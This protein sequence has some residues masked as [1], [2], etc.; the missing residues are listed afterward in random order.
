MIN[1]FI[2]NNKHW[3]GLFMLIS[4]IGIPLLGIFIITNFSEKQVF[5]LKFIAL[6]SSISNLIIT[7]IFYFWFNFSSNNF[8]FVEEQYNIQT[9]DIYLGIDGISLYFI[10]LTTIIMVSTVQV[11]SDCKYYPVNFIPRSFI[12]LFS[13]ECWGNM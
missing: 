3:I 5:Y 6:S 4:L 11:N 10:L 12:Y 13:F 9:F 8:Q 1:N 7:F 2:S